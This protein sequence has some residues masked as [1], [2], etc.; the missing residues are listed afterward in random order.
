MA[1][2]MTT[3]HRGLVLAVAMLGSMTALAQQAAN[4]NLNDYEVHL[5]RGLAQRQQAAMTY[6]KIAVERASS[7]L[8]KAVAKRALEIHTAGQTSISELGKKLAAWG[9]VGQGPVGPGGAGGPGGAAPQG[10]GGPPGGGAGAPPQG[11]AGPQAAGGA[12]AGAPQGA[13]PQG[14]AGMGGGNMLAFATPPGG[15]F[16]DALKKASGVEFDRLYLLL[17]ILQNEEMQRAIAMQIESV[18]TKPKTN[19]ELTQW[20][21]DHVETYRSL[22]RVVQKAVRGE[23]ESADNPLN[24]ERGAVDIERKPQ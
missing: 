17:T 13:A 24:R 3:A 20:S 8:T 1:I 19:A 6:D 18:A 10:A 12:P 2:K 7:D 22:A 9:A 23:G 21:K 4:P 14:A 15:S 5:V 16:E 11:G